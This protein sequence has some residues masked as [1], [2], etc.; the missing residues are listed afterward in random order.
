MN[1]SIFCTVIVIIV[2]FTRTSYATAENELPQ[3]DDEP[4]APEYATEPAVSPL[5][6]FEFWY[7]EITFATVPAVA[8]LVFDEANINELFTIV[9]FENKL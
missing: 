3:D 9:E 6:F 2:K 1:F 5:Q 8:P 4:L 7:V